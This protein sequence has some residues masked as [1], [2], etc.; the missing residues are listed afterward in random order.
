M[1]RSRLAGHVIRMVQIGRAVYMAD[2]R[3]RC[4]WFLRP[5]P[6]WRDVPPQEN[7]ENRRSIDGYRRVFRDGRTTVFRERRRDARR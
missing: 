7:E 4:Y 6:D 1:P 2:D 3:R 5:N